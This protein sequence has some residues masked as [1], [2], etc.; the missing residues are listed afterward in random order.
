SGAAGVV[1]TN[2]ATL[3]LAAGVTTS[4]PLTL[5]SASTSPGALFSSSGTNAWSGPVTLAVTA[6][7]NVQTNSSLNLSGIISG[8]GGLTKI[9]PGTLAYSGSGANS[10][11]GP[12]LVN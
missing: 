1:I 10:Y 8:P 3:Q 6:T 4:R 12:T 11:T 9:G 2:N 7:V 5:H